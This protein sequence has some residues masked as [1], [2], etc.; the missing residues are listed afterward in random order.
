MID[1]EKEF[2]IKIEEAVYRI[3]KREGIC[4][5]PSFQT[6]LTPNEVV[7]SESDEE[8]LSDK[9]LLVWLGSNERGAKQNV[10]CN[11]FYIS[12][13][14]SMSV[15]KPIPFE[16]VFSIWEAYFNG[17]SPKDIYFTFIFDEEDVDISDIKLVIWALLHGKC[18]YLLSF[19]REDRYNFDFKKYSGRY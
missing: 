10:K 9:Q 1:T 11:Q 19:V 14:G 15:T 17:C 6:T 7:L 2:E 13:R 16:E 3:L 4:P 18:N 5:T 12:E 8:Y